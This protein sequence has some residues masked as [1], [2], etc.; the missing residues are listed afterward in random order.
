MVLARTGQERT[1]AAFETS[2]F[3]ILHMGW[4]IH[5]PMDHLLIVSTF[6]QGLQTLSH[7]ASSTHLASLLTSALQEGLSWGGLAQLWAPNNHTQA[8]SSHSQ[9]LNGHINAVSIW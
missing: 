4:V 1:A 6:S 3:S 2:H 7:T 8:P 5:H 9:Q